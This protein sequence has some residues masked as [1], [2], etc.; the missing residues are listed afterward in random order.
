MH[1]HREDTPSNPITGWLIKFLVLLI[2]VLCLIA[3]VVLSAK[4]VQ[5]QY[6]PQAEMPK[7][8]VKYYYNFP[9]EVKDVLSNSIISVQVRTE[10]MVGGVSEAR[11]TTSTGFVVDNDGFV[12]AALHSFGDVPS[13]WLNN[14]TKVR[15]FD[16]TNYLDSSLIGIDPNADLVLI[17]VE[18]T[19]TPGVKFTKKAVVMAENKDNLP[20]H[21]YAVR[22]M[23]FGPGLYLPVKLGQYL[24]ETNVTGG[25][26]LP[27]MMGAVDGTIEEGF[28]GGPLIGPDGKIYGVI[29][30][31]G[32]A[33]T[34]VVPLERASEFI[35]KGI[36]MFKG[37]EATP[38][39]TD[40]HKPSQ[41]L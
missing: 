23:P 28:S 29:V 18:G 13:A 21:F 36:K 22:F 33:F 12:L 15:I 20:D 19:N 39:P 5:G 9:A 4:K 38:P 14:S 6:L 35:R 8:V 30:R 32:E 27:I 3:V 37:E 34:Y 40:E 16:G 41:K 1:H 26:I 2:A 10:T 31:R 25:H 24:L 11:D 17:K 7:I